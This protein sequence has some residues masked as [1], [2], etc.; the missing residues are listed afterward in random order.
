MEKFPKMKCTSQKY[1]LKKSTLPAYMD[2][3]RTKSSLPVTICTIACKN[4]SGTDS[5]DVR[6]FQDVPYYVEYH[7]CDRDRTDVVTLGAAAEIYAKKVGRP[8]EVQQAAF[9]NG[10]M[11]ELDG[12]KIEMDQGAIYGLA[13]I[14]IDHGPMTPLG[15]I[16]WQDDSRTAEMKAKILEEEAAI[17]QHAA[18]KQD[19]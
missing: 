1:T 7:Q 8:V 9:S 15:T 14:N 16:N 17:A 5:H 19:L 12:F 11:R 3:Q 2:N 4:G 6:F 10:I 18:Q 13:W